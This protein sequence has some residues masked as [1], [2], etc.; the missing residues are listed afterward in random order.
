YHPRLTKVHP[1]RSF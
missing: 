1:M